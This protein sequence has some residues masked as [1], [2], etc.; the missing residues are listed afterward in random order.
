MI[1]INDLKRS[2]KYDADTGEFTRLIS[3][4][5]RRKGDTVGWV[6][7]SNGIEYLITKVNRN[8][9]RL[10]RLAFFYMTG[11]WPNQVDHING[12]GT[13][14]RWCNLREVFGNE[15]NK[16][17]RLLKN[18]KSGCCGVS[19]RKSNQM[20]TSNITVHR[21]QIHLGY[22]ADFFEACC[23]RKSADRKYGFH[24]NHGRNLPK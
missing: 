14:N 4:G 21:K 16:N 12:I 24:L 2:L 8:K 23:A 17:T 10:H 5:C 15:N 18:N 20:F 9:V 1:D 7:R 19:F 3:G 6:D 22:F 13:D 11:R